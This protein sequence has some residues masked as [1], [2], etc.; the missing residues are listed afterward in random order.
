MNACMDAI[1]DDNAII[2]RPSDFDQLNGY[3]DT[4]VNHS[5]DAH[6]AECLQ[7]VFCSKMRSIARSGARTASFDLQDDEIAGFLLTLERR[8]PHSR[9][10][11]KGTFIRQSESL[12]LTGYL[13][14][15]AREEKQVNHNAND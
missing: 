4:A 10:H 14:Y 8:Y 1:I 7:R 2:Q 9:L 12:T 13:D 11:W 6:M 3:I 5:I 15:Q